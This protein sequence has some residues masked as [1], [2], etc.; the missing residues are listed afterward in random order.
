ML[1]SEINNILLV[2]RASGKEAV[3]FYSCKQNQTLMDFL[4]QRSIPVASSC[5][6]DGICKKCEVSMNLQPILS[7]QIKLSNLPQ[8]CRVQIDYL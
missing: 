4:H 6:G 3:L 2:G 1:S 8:P 5:K 7:C